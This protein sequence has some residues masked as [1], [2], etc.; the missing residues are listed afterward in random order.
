[1]VILSADHEAE[2]G[3]WISYFLAPENRKNQFL[4][5]KPKNAND[6]SFERVPRAE[7]NDTKISI[8][9]QFWSEIQIPKI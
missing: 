6:S 9:S 3:F 1:M 7:S 8:R 4:S 5:E 2:L